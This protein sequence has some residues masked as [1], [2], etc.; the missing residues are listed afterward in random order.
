MKKLQKEICLL[1]MILG[2]IGLSAQTDSTSL[3]IKAM[4]TELK[5]IVD[6]E[7]TDVMHNPAAINNISSNRI[8]ASVNN[9][10]G[11]K[12][13]YLKNFDNMDYHTNC[14]TSTFGGLFKFSGLYFGIGANYGINKTWDDKARTMSTSFSMH[15]GLGWTATSQDIGATIVDMDNGTQQLDD[16]W[17]IYEETR[18][19]RYYE[20][21]TQK[22]LFLTLGF[23][24]LGFSYRFLNSETTSPTSDLQY[25]SHTY[26]LITIGHNSPAEPIN[27]YQNEINEYGSKSI[28]HIFSFGTIMKIGEKS[29]IDL[30]AGYG[31]FSDDFNLASRKNKEIDFDPDNDGNP[32]MEPESSNKR[33]YYSY[34]QNSDNIQELKG[35]D[36]RLETKYTFLLNKAL[37][38]SL[39]GGI[40]KNKS[41]EGKY[42]MQYKSQELFTDFKW[43]TV[44]DELIHIASTGDKETKQYSYYYG[45]GAVS[46]PMPNL[47]IGAAIKKYISNSKIDYSVHSTNNGV[48]SYFTTNDEIERKNLVIPIGLEYSFDNKLDMRL[49]ICTYFYSYEKTIE[50]TYLTLIANGWNNLDFLPS[51]SDEYTISYFSFGLGYKLFNNIKI[52]ITGIQEINGFTNY[53]LSVFVNF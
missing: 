45:I 48:S 50:S 18:G 29:K 11:L 53:Y 10:A 20:D 33:D 8:I 42:K 22:G 14:G 1:I 49:G 46:T 44:T 35:Q 38:F 52:D 24:N 17:R 6:D 3:R 36:I 28:Q 23:K 19:L 47:I 9:Q 4:G 37:R 16:D 32:Y 26:N 12:S 2:W 13:H 7:Y 43:G 34:Q 31:V 21:I 30:V 40:F 39:W 15:E 5:W 41:N 27:A 25:A 51:E